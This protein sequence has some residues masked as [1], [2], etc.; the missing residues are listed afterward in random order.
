[1]LPSRDVLGK[2]G[3]L[4]A[5]LA[6]LLILIVFLWPQSRPGPQ[7]L[8]SLPPASSSANFASS[9]SRP[10]QA[11]PRSPEPAR[12]IDAAPNPPVRSDPPP[13]VLP[14][15]LESPV[16]RT[17]F[18]KSPNPPELYSVRA[19]P[20]TRSRF[21]PYGRLLRCQL[22]NA[23]DSVNV[24]TPII[25]LVT[26]NL[27]FNSDLIVPA[28]AEIHGKAKIE[29][30]RDRLGSSGPWTLVWPNGK[31]LSLS[32][33][34]LDREFDISALVYGITDGSYGLKGSVLRSDSLPEVKLFAASALSAVA[35]GFAETRQTALGSFLPRTGRNAGSAATQAVLDRYAEQVLEEV[36]Q[37]GIFVRVPG[38]TEFS[39]Y[40][41]QSI[42]PDLALRGT[43]TN[44]VHANK[45][46]VLP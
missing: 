18:L 16:P 34:A 43:S 5:G 26:H 14:Q 32:G 6:V 36:K 37:N 33:L 28:G 1:M 12:K 29:R 27:Y 38:G 3:L 25:G 44:N 17:N 10:A 39:V 45:T 42:E 15:P 23:I 41:T 21:A 24:E 8:L 35:A 40:I 9:V 19:V 46:T 22:V 2:R 13:T 30:I 7:A 11:L 20:A 31:T 4:L